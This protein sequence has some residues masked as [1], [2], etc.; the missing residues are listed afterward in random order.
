M[1][2]QYVPDQIAAV[3][4][5][6]EHSGRPMLFSLSPGTDDP[7]QAKEVSSEVTMYRVTGDTWD[8]WP[9][10]LDHFTSAQ[11][12]QPFIARP[13]GRYD[14]PSWPDLDMVRHRTAASHSTTPPYH[15]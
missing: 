10:L 3:S 5:A 12:M 6:I 1:Y 13:H 7:D 9:Q 11:H 4:A 2:A 8:R 14:L 15:A